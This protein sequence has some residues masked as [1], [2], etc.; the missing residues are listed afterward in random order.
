MLER[1]FW[2]RA[3]R[4]AAPFVTVGSP[5]LRIIP[6]EPKSF[7]LI[8]TESHG[9]LRDVSVMGNHGD[10]RRGETPRPT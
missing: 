4:L 7:C 2:G 5:R 6:R 9:A 8:P 10:E 3:Q 1:D